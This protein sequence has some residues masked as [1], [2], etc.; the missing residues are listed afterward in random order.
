MTV[1][2]LI[3]YL[4]NLPGDL[5]VGIS[6]KATSGNLCQTLIFDNTKES[7]IILDQLDGESKVK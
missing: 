4:K 5:T 2:R 7:D 1:T 3:N 6:G